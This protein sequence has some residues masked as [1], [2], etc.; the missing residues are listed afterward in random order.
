MK[1]L[2]GLGNPGRKYEKTKHN[3]GFMVVDELLRN[4]PGFHMKRSKFQSMYEEIRVDGEPVVFIQPTTYMNLSGESIRQWMDFYKVEP[5]DIFVIYDDMDLPAG[6]IRIRKKGG[7][8]GHNGMRSLIDHLGTKD[9]IRLKV[10]IDRP[11]PAQSVTQ[12]VLSPFRKDQEDLVQQAIDQAAK[13]CQD[14]LEGETIE[15]VM[16]KYN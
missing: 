3:V 9:F 7:H 6:K 1:L 2:I 4:Q 14:W 11:L 8:G 5:K 10:G 15:N 16:T 13:A 12:H